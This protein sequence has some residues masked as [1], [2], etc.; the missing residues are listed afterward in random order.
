VPGSGPETRVG[1]A[2]SEADSRASMRFARCAGGWPARSICSAQS[3][4]CSGATGRAPRLAEELHVVARIPD[5]GDALL[6]AGD[7]DAVG[8]EQEP[9]RVVAAVQVRRADRSGP[10]EALQIRPGSAE[11]GDPGEVGVLCQ[12]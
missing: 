3:T 10:V 1:S 5:E 9:G 6:V 8:R 4:V 7:V 11:V 2:M 12:R